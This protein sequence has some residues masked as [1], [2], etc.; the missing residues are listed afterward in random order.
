MDMLSAY[1]KI[2]KS[3]VNYDGNND[4]A[5]TAANDILGGDNIIES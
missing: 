5:A 3:I 1:Q 2:N 4:F